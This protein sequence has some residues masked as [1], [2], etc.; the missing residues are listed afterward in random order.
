VTKAGCITLTQ[1]QNEHEMAS[2]NIAQEKEAE[3]N[4]LRL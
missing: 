3:N 1:K 2:H 4:A